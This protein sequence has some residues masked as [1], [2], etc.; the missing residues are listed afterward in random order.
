MER[1]E[2]TARVAYLEQHIRELQL[3]VQLLEG[4]STRGIDPAGP[5]RFQIP[6]PPVHLAEPNV[7]APR[8]PV[9]EAPSEGP[10]RSSDFD[11]EY[12]LGAQLLPRIGVGVFLLGMLFLVAMAIARG[13]IS[14]ELQWAGEI[15]LCAVLMVVGLWKRNEKEDFGQLLLGMGSC[16]LYFSFAGAHAYKD[17]L[18]GEMLVA[19]FTVWSLANVG[20][21]LWQKSRPFL[22][23]GLAGGLI[24]S[25]LPLREEKVLL[26]L[27]LHYAILVPALVVILRQR[28]TGA[29]IGT[30]TASFVALLPAIFSP[31]APWRYRAGAL[32]LMTLACSVAYGALHSP[33][34]EE[35]VRADSKGIFVAFVATLSALLALAIGPSGESGIAIVLFAG[36]LA[37]PFRTRLA[38]VR[39]CLPGRRSLRSLS[40][41]SPSRVP[42]EWWSLVLWRSFSPARR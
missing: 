29:V 36:A 1:D 20:L 40:L 33:E 26:T 14:F 23:I 37:G 39:S 9:T 35:S 4:Q 8:V 21:S 22:V 28:W 31:A 41:R 5:P 10:R 25:V 7:A 19:L 38:T 24:G 42:S 17:L 34:D 6:P 11:A 30:W 13:W 2:L 3:R 27:A 15:S 32:L 18:S 16:G 12:K